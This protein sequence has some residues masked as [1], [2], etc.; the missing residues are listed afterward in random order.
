MTQLS[1]R[2][3]QFVCLGDYA[4]KEN[5]ESEA[6]EVETNEEN[7]NLEGP[8][9]EMFSPAADNDND[10]EDDNCMYNYI[11]FLWPLKISAIKKGAFFRIM[12]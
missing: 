1:L 11:H 7:D 3:V 10:N 5:E 8:I 2:P 12:L 9:G 4:P 6:N